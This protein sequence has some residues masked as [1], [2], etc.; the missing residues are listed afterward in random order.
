MLDQH[1]HAQANRTQLFGVYSEVKGYVCCAV[2]DMVA[3]MWV[4]LTFAG[5]LLCTVAG[6][7]ALNPSPERHL[8][9][10]EACTH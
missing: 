3:P 10:D 4:G 5:V 8:A 6:L 7:S 9:L 1:T 2:P